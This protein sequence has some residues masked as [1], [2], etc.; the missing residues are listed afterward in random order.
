MVRDPLQEAGQIIE[1]ILNHPLSIPDLPEDL[2][3]LQAAL[4]FKEEEPEASSLKKVIDSFH[5]HPE[6][7]ELLIRELEILARELKL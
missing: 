2:T 1:N 6:V 4:S 5:D 7:K 3:L